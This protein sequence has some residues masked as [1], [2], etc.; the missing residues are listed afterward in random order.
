MEYPLKEVEDIDSC[1]GDE[2]PKL[3][4]MSEYIVNAYYMQKAINTIGWF[5][6]A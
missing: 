3:E 5:E 1:E 6:R 4:Q 2:S